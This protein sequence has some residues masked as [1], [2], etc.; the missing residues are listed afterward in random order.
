MKRDENKHSFRDSDNL[1]INLE[2]GTVSEFIRNSIKIRLN[3]DEKAYIEEQATL[4]ELINFYKDKIEAYD[5][6]LEKAEEEN[7]KINKSKKDAMI[8]LEKLEKE[9]QNLEYIVKKQRALQEEDLK[10][11]RKYTFETLINNILNNRKDPTIPLFNIE[12]MQKDCQYKTLKEFKKEVYKYIRDSTTI[13]S[14]KI[15]QEDVDY[16][17]KKIGDT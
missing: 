15:R 17:I 12:Y 16:I 8:K 14:S 6:I 10:L 1:L 11:K 2:K 9:R 5:N 4:N 7:K 3:I 13:D